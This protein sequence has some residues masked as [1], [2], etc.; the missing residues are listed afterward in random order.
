MVRVTF[1]LLLTA[2]A[3][4]FHLVD[5]AEERG[6]TGSDP[7]PEKYPVCGERR[8]SPV[9][10]ELTSTV[11]GSEYTSLEFHGYDATPDDVSFTLANKEHTVQV[12]LVNNNDSVGISAGALPNLYTLQQFHFHWGTV[13]S[14]GSE[15]TIDGHQYPM[16]M[17]L[18]HYNSK[19]RTIN[20]AVNETL[21][22]AVLGVFVQIGDE[23]NTAFSKFIDFFDEIHEVEA[24]RSLDT[25]PLK[26]LLPRNTAE[27]FRYNGSL[28]TAPCY[29]SVIWT[30]FKQPVTI[31]EYQMEAFRKLYN[32]RTGGEHDDHMRNNFR[33]T[34]PLYGRTVYR[35]YEGAESDNA[36]IFACSGLVL[37][38][39]ALL[40]YLASKLT[41]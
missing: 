24:T 21:G 38:Q 25:F 20:D 2:V 3:S 39:S 10:I 34:K 30:V 12:D 23:H 31:T 14:V 9:D 27:Y 35:S 13:D 40:V 17:H 29:Q 36:A 16:E 26:R 5:A 32:N 8:Q 18:V 4:S 11:F 41:I 37:L 15:H 22:L 19:A 7:S 33:P 28:T 6:A 1:C